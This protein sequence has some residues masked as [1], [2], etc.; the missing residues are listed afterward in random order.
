MARPARPEQT[1]SA[2]SS[3]PLSRFCYLINPDKV[4]GTHKDGQNETE[5]PDHSASLVDSIT[6]STR[7]RFSVHTG[8]FPGYRTTEAHRQGVISID[9]VIKGSVSEKSLTIDVQ[10]CS[11]LWA[12]R[13]PFNSRNILKC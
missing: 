9:E 13:A 8:V 1:K 4:F 5:Q 2:R 10:R 11:R 6:S 12:E 7:I 3:R